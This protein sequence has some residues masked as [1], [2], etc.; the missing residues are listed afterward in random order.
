MIKSLLFLYNISGAAYK[1]DL[2]MDTVI[3]ENPILVNASGSDSF[4]FSFTSNSWMSGFGSG[5]VQ[6]DFT[7]NLDLGMQ[8]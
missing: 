6:G 5:A 3:D 8:H 7:R 1:N 4:G 2:V